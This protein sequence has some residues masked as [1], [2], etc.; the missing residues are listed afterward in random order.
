MIKKI[1]HKLNRSPQPTSPYTVSSSVRV[2]QQ[3][4]KI[5]VGH[6]KTRPDILRLS[7]MDDLPKNIKPVIIPSI[8]NAV[9]RSSALFR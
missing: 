5:S 3:L 9:A 2:F 1:S 4:R 7:P 8:T 6:G